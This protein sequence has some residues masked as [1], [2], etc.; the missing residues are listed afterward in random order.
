M[1]IASVGHGVF[2]VTLIGFG[3]LGLVKSEYAALWKG[4]PK[5][6]PAHEALPYLCALVSIICGLGL[7]WRRT[8]AP[9]A[10]LLLA[11]LVAWSLLFKARF[12]LV[13]PFAEFVYQSCGQNAVI[14]AAAWVLY[15]WFATDWDRK[16][17]HFATG[18]KG[19]CIA[20]VLYGLALIAFGF[21]HFAYL[22][23]T[24]PLIPGWLLWPVFWSYFTGTAYLAAGVAVLVGVWARL[25]AALSALQMGSFIFLVWLPITLAGKMSDFN[26]GELATT[27]LLTAGAWV[28]AD[29][30]GSVPWLSRGRLLSRK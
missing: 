18:E 15:T 24:A 13:A 20:R 5:D 4:V 6:M 27:C 29:S 14:I 17:V 23:L 8:A 1:R 25:A 2:A 30:Y 28:V 10:R 22:N 7:L 11:Y 21:S 26:W 16:H 3:I 9:A 12:I 19:V